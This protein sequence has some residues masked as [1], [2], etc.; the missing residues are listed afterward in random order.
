MKTTRSTGLRGS[1]RFA[2][3]LLELLAVMAI[4]ALLLAVL[5]P[6]LAGINE[7]NNISRA[8]Q[9]FTDQVSLARQIASARNITVEVRCIQIPVRSAYG[10]TA[11]QLWSSSGTTASPLSRLQ[12]LPDGIVIG[13]DTTKVSSL[14]ASYQSTGTMPVGGPDSGDTYVSFTIHPSGTLGPLSTTSVTPNMSNLVVGIV[15]ARYAQ[16]TTLPVNYML[17]QL[18]PITAATAAYRP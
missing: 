17:V 13:Q 7:S 6:S 10:Y 9:L 3:T 12:T 4:M 2:Y 5:V 14:F 8:G 18:N 11:I 15:P 16:N 1:S